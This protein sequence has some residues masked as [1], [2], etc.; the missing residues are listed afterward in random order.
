MLMMKV[1]LPEGQFVKMHQYSLPE[2]Y[3]KKI[4]ENLDKVK[5]YKDIYHHIVYNNNL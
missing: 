1:Q 5:N 3:L 4:I 2:I